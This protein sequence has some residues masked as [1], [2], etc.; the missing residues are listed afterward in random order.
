MPT[1][2][3]VLWLV[4]G[5]ATFDALVLTLLFLKVRTLS[6][7]GG[8]TLLVIGAGLAGFAIHALIFFNGGFLVVQLATIAGT[9]AICLLAPSKPHAKDEP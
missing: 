7:F 8:R 2:N 3:T 9:F 5:L 4:L 6:P 1:M